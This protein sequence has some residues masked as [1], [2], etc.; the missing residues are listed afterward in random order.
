[1]LNEW[2]GK[3]VKGQKGKKDIEEILDF[4]F[5]ILNYCVS[6]PL[7]LIP[8][9]YKEEQME[10]KK[11]LRNVELKKYVMDKEASEGVLASCKRGSVSGPFSGW[12]TCYNG[13]FWCATPNQS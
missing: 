11:K 1:M 9:P 7:T 8:Y 4:E 13:N 10:E 3:R 5:W 12:P 6:C 2:I